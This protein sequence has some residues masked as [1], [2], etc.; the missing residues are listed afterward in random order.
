MENCS[1][2]AAAVPIRPEGK[3]VPFERRDDKRHRSVLRVGKIVSGAREELCMI[4]N[5]S[6]GGL[7]AHVYA[8]YEPDQP[9]AI[10][11][12]NG[13]VQTGRVAWFDSQMMGVEFSERIDVL[14][15]LAT[16]QERLL[17]GFVPRAPRL[18]TD[19]QGLIRRGAEYMRVQMIDISQGGA[20]L[21]SAVP[22]AVDDDVVLTLRDLPAVHAGVRWTDG[23]RAG[24]SFHDFIPFETLAQW[25]VERGPLHS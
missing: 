16:E 11:I 2:A 18:H 24:L 4:R 13:H 5:I 17:N 19:V 1:P 7:M 20:K 23:E 12:R 21:F 9:V 8:G 15:F 3:L 25:I 14:D 6:A 22:L 10:E